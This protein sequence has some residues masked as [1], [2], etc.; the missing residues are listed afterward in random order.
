V[1]R[2]GI[3]G[4]QVERRRTHIEGG[5]EALRLLRRITRIQTGAWTGAWTPLAVRVL[6]AAA[7]APGPYVRALE[8]SARP[9]AALAKRR[10]DARGWLVFAAQAQR[11][12]RVM[13]ASVI[14]YGCG[15]QRR[16]FGATSDRGPAL[17]RRTRLPMSIGVYRSLSGAIGVYRSLSRS[18]HLHAKR[19]VSS[20]KGDRVPARAV[21]GFELRGALAAIVNGPRR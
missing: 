8:Q 1:Q 4:Q 6:G 15:D 10:R 14:R 13:P 7:A 21:P 12:S 11:C 9:G 18:R 2:P 20:T 5:L 16:L 17:R 19:Q 3:G